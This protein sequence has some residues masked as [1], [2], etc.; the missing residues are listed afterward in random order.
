[1]GEVCHGRPVKELHADLQS[2]RELRF[3]YLG[4][5]QDRTTAILNYPE[6]RLGRVTGAPIGGRSTKGTHPAIAKR[7]RMSDIYPIDPLDFSTIDLFGR[8]VE[9]QRSRFGL[10]FIFLHLFISLGPP[11]CT[12]LSQMHTSLTESP[13]RLLGIAL[14]ANF[15][16]TVTYIRL[17][18]GRSDADQVADGMS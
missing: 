4:G 17:Q 14:S 3:L 5:N 9:N 2:H 8:G 1:M 16:T 15:L 11:R 18:H 7:P 10:S 6:E 13:L 12:V